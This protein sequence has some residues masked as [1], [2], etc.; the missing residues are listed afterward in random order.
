MT[1]DDA[2]ERTLGHEGGYVNNVEDP[3]GETQWGISKRSYPDLDIKTLTVAQA[4][5]IYQRDYWTPAGCEHVPEAIRAD[6]FD[7]AVNAGVRPAIKALQRAVGADPDGVIG[8]QTIALAAVVPPDRL[9][10]RFNAK[11]LRAYTEAKAW[12]AFGRGWVL[13][14]I[15]NM[16]A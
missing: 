8:P 2:F 11:R 15:A 16:E 10:L 6:L 14:T 4:K 3:G 9:R 5:A 1:F 13:R 12:S 7:M